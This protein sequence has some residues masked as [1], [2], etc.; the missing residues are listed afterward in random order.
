MEQ[1]TQEVYIDVVGKAFKKNLK[2]LLLKIT[3]HIADIIKLIFLMNSFRA[4]R[5]GWGI[6][7]LSQWVW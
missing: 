5:Q 7:L 3:C 6:L 1:R 2:F 4:S